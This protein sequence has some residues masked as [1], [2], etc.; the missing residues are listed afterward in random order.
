MFFTK[1]LCTVTELLSKIDLTVV[2][3]FLSGALAHAGVRKAI[4]I[5]ARYWGDKQV[6]DAAATPDPQDDAAALAKQAAAQ[7]LADALEKKGG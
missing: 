4:A 3:T 7:Q 6:L 5:A 1:L 2:L